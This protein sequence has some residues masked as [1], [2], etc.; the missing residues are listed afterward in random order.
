MTNDPEARE[1]MTDV[2]IAAWTCSPEFKRR[3]WQWQK[4][5]K[6]LYA[7]AGDDEPEPSEVEAMIEG[8]G[9]AVGLPDVVGRGLIARWAD[10]EVYVAFLAKRRGRPQ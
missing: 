8:F 3:A 1:R 10:P 4:E 2:E 7:A 5:L 6:A 9:A